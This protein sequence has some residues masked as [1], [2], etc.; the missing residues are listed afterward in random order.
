MNDLLRVSVRKAI[1]ALAV[2]AVTIASFEALAGETRDGEIHH[3]DVAQAAV[4]HD[5]LHLRGN[6]GYEDSGSPTD[7]SHGPEHRHG[8]SADH[9]THVHGIGLTSRA[10]LVETSLL[11]TATS[12]ELLNAPTDRNTPAPTQ[13]PKA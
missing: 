7:R 11:T 5:A 8:T 3:E 9:C 13:P 1:S 2:A 4:H 6:H 10:T 12:F